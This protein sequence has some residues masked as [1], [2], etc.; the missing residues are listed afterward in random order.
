M[1]KASKRDVAEKMRERY[2]KVS[3]PEKGRLI[4]EL[5]ELTGYH[6]GHAQRL[7]RGGPPRTALG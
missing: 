1:R 7:L 2:V 6:R 3:R 4:D 5:V